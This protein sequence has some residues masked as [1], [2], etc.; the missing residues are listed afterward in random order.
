MIE[1]DV[2]MIYTKNLIAL[3]HILDEYEE[4]KNR[5]QTVMNKKFNAD[6]IKKIDDVST[7]NFSC[8]IKAMEFYKQNKRVIDTINQYT[9]ISL[10]INDNNDCELNAIDRVDY[11]YN[12]LKKHRDE[13]DKIL[14]LLDK[15]SKLH[16]VTVTLNEN[17]DFSC[18]TYDI[19]TWM[20]DNRK[21]VLLDNMEAVPGYSS[22][23][24][25]YKTTG[26]NYKITLSGA[27]GDLNRY[28]IGKI[29]LDSLT[30]DESRLPDNLS[31]EEVYQTILE[32][33]DKKEDE[34]AAIKTSVDL[35][36]GIE[37]LY[38]VFTII[39]QRI[40][41]LEDSE[42]KQELTHQLTTIKTAILKMQAINEQMDADVIS[43]AL[44]SKETLE[45]EKQLCKKDKRR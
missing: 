38:K 45:R 40:E 19:H 18:E 22:D 5:L 36:V 7:G 6:F 3:C 11:F 39:S 24:V 41:N 34:Y 10:F 13:M 27:F 29:V 8:S 28:P 33:K 2:H 14:K 26:S 25:R 23:L 43:S 42:K 35:N 9:N 32:L 31:S 15:L 16:I 12:Y 30:F 37:D 21:L 4:F 17:I 44:V 20:P 1:N